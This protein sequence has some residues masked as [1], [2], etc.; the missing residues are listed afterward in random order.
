MKRAQAPAPFIAEAALFRLASRRRRPDNHSRDMSHDAGEVSWQTLR[1]IVHEWAGDRAEI[2][3][4]AS[5]DGGS[6]STTLRIVT[7]SGDKAVL[8][9]SPHRI[10][11]SYERE[12]RQLDLLRSIGIPTPRVFGKHIGTLDQPDSYLL[13]EYLP[14]IN[15]HDAKLAASPE[16]FDRLQEQ[17]AEHVLAIHSHTAEHYGKVDEPAAAKANGATWPVF[18]RSL[19]EEIWH[20]CQKH[21]AIP[22]KCRKQIEKVHDRLEQL[23]D[24]DDSPRLT[25]GDLWT[26]NVLAKKDEPDGKW[27]ITGLLDPNCKFAHAESELAYLDLF[28]TTTPA[29]NKAYQKKF[30]IGDDYHRLRKPVYQLY[31][32]INHVNLFGEKYLKPMRETLEKVTAVM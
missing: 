3:E 32:L 4:V 5:M 8:K 17:L 22:S 1:R 23:L 13:I 10:D 7:K 6:I 15:L 19:Y 28:H 30:K 29:F 20:E 21:A 27:T 2:E 18:Y 24:H 9:L 31:E 11:R 16:E 12:A 25:H 26:S 14:G